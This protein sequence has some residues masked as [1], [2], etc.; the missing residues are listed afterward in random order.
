MTGR[1]RHGVPPEHFEGAVASASGPSPRTG[2]RWPRRAGRSPGISQAPRTSSRHRHQPLVD[3][4][5]RAGRFRDLVERAGETARVRSR[6][7]CTSTPASNSARTG[8]ASGAQSLSIAL[9]NSSPS[10]TRH[11]RHPMAADVT[12]QHDDVA[13]RT[14]ARRHVPAV[15]DEADPGG[16]HEHRP[17]PFPLSTT[18][19]S[20]VTTRTPAWRRR[21]A[22]SRDAP[23]ASRSGAPPR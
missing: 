3:R 7:Q 18:F 13:R 16:R 2:P 23:P 20:P 11:D 5:A 9:S 14:R 8:P 22:W 4:H 12:A 21:P 15:L 1:R 19:V 17:S 6:R 10:R